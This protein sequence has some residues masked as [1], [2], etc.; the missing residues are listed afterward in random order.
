RERARQIDREQIVVRRERAIVV[1]VL[2]VRTEP[3]EAGDDRLPRFRV[4]AELA[5]QLEQLERL[6]QR[7]RRFSLA[8]DERR[9]LWLLFRSSFRRLAEL[10]VRAEAAVNRVDVHPGPRIDAEDARTFGLRANQ[11]RRL[12][13]AEIGRRQVRRQRRRLPRPAFALLQE[14]AVAAD[15]H[16]DR[17]TRLG[18]DADVDERIVG[19]LLRLLHGMLEPA[20][21]L[22]AAIELADEVEPFALAARDLVEIFLHLRGEAQVDQIVE[23]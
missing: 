14:R 2:H 6:L 17:F 10:H 1:A 16:A 12:V 5:R 22:V 9:A 18:I 20:V 19:A 21:A 3:A 7:D 8:A 23:V 11:R 4:R 13:D 15:A